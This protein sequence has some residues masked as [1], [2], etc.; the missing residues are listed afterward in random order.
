VA[1][2]LARNA[3]VGVDAALLGTT[4][5]RTGLLDR[6]QARDLIDASDRA[7]VLAQAPTSPE[8][9]SAVTREAAALSAV[10]RVCDEVM[11]AA[12][13]AAASEALLGRLDAAGRAKITFF[14][15]A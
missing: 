10:C 12:E 8:G 7:F 9:D 15:H 4:A 11:L 1:T 6:Q 2:T 5:D 3:S 13:S 14:V